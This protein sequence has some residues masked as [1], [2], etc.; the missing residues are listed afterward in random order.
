MN[1]LL[2]ESLFEKGK[3]SDQKLIPNST[4]VKKNQVN[5]NI[6]IEKLNVSLPERYCGPS[7][8]VMSATSPVYQRLWWRY[9]QTGGG[10]AL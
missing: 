7:D 5:N 1:F 3:D 4:S 8:P 10:S 2:V 6:N 9:S